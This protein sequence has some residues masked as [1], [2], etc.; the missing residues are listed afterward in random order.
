[1]RSL[2]EWLSLYAESHQNPTNKH[3][4]WV[5]VP[6]I[7]FS[8]LAL[9]WSIPFSALDGWLNPATIVV[10]LGLL[11]YARLSWRMALG[12]ALVC[13]G[14]LALSAW[15]ASVLVLWQFALGVFVVAWIGQFYGHKIEGAKPSF[16]EDIQFLLI[17]PAWTLTFLYKKLGIP[18]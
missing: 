7:F 10:A 11:F 14:C 3:I 18:Y 13:A 5:C 15:L 8:V 4:H 1:M 2:D 6:A 12:V 17:G 16:I 9:L